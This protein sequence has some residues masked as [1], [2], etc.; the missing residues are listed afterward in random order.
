MK[1]MLSIDVEDYYHVS[2]LSSVIRRADWENY[3]KRV[4]EN[5]HK[6]LRLLD[7]HNTKATFFILGIVAESFPELVKAIHKAGHEIASHGYGHQPV[8]ELT[9]TQFQ[10]DL[11]RSVYTLEGITSEPIKGYRAP[12]FSIIETTRWALDVLLDLGFRY[13]SSIYPIQYD[14]YGWP[15]AQRF[16][17][18]VKSH[19]DDVLWEF[20]PCTIRALGR[21]IPIAG[22]GYFRFFPYRFTKACIQK[23]NAKGLPAMVYLHPWEFDPDQPKFKPEFKNRIRHYLNL[24]KTESRFSELLKDFT[25]TT[26]SDFATQ[27]KSPKQP[28]NEVKSPL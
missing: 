10:Q 5:T 22:G 28:V 8:Y 23:L 15:N 6:I 21:N 20:P 26:I 7:V 12:S 14:R 25:F 4:V 11:Q 17:H 2:G 24:D 19:G 9:E 16:P 13:D 27:L 18:V 1:N 3:P